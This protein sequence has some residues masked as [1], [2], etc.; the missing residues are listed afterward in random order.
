MPN[1]LADI[2]KISSRCQRKLLIFMIVSLMQSFYYH[3]PI[4]LEL[5]SISFH[6]CDM[7]PFAKSRFLSF[8]REI[9]D[10]DEYFSVSE[11]HFVKMI[12]FISKNIVKCLVGAKRKSTEGK[13][14]KLEWKHFRLFF[15]SAKKSFSQLYLV[16]HRL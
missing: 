2:K 4:C 12:S 13:K 16:L 1:L 3:E 14:V 9:L 15:Y 10:D 6:Y 11:C 5:L 8:I 7:N